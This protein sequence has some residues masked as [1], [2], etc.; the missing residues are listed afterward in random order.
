M[1][2]R[3]TEAIILRTYPLSEA[4]K[5]VSFFSRGGGRTRGVAHNA[6]R[7]VKRFGASL[8]R[9]SHVRVRYFEQESRELVRL[10]S[11][12]LVQSFFE[13]QS[14]YAAGVAFSYIA[15]VC[16]LLL[17]E[18]EVNDPFFR[19]VL[20]VMNEIGHGDIW[21]PLTY[22]D[23]WA[24]T[25]AGFLPPL[26]TCSRCQ[27]SLDPGE[28]AWFRL[29]SQGLQCKTC[30]SDGSWSLSG[31]SRSLAHGMME[32][33]LA[34]IPDEGWGKSRAEDL[35]RLLEQQ[36]EKHLE[37]KLITRPLVEGL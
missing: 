16:E 17:P 9:L 25:L 34:A 35:R 28:A 18:R 8:E 6:R 32:R 36:V 31:D 22:F 1:P 20:L 12:E 13:L 29:E 15:E 27:G 24:V 26:D 5:I 37:R 4:D 14:D 19:L 23:L 33:S 7:S 10:E 21:R 3:E 11:C 2:V 30:R